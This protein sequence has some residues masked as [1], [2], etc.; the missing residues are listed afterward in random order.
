M[1]RFVGVV[2]FSHQFDL[3]N[4][5]YKVALLALDSS[6]TAPEVW[7]LGTLN[8]WFKEGQ[9]EANNQRMSASYFPRREIIAQFPAP[10]E[11]EKNPIVS[12]SLVALITLT[13]YSLHLLSLWRSSGLSAFTWHSKV[14]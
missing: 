1:G 12:L 9:S 5:N 2:D 6:A 4:G 3:V 14:N 7:Q 10:N 13:F 8:V 11:K